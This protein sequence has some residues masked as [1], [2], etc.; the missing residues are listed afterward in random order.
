[1][2]ENPEEI[3]EELEETMQPSDGEDIWINTMQEETIGHAQMAIEMA[4][5][6]TKQHGK[7]EVKLPDEFK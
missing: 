3:L 2:E 7:E 6:Y 1:M 4:H 5:E